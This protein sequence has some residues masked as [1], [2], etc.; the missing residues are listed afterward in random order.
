[1]ASNEGRN[2][3]FLHKQ[4]YKFCE[5]M[6]ELTPLQEVFLMKANNLEIDESENKD[7]KKDR[8]E[9]SNKLQ[10]KIKSKNSN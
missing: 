5:Y 2:V 7:S 4:G 3:W 8:E 1:M 9:L 6:E 10:A